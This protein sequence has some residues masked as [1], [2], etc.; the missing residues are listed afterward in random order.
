MCD[1][2]NIWYE[3]G[4]LFEG[5]ID[6]GSDIYLASGSDPTWTISCAGELPTPV[7]GCTFCLLQ[8]NCGCGVSS[9]HF[10]IPSKIS[11]CQSNLVLKRPT[12]LHLVNMHVMSTFFANLARNFTATT[13][14]ELHPQIEVPPLEALHAD[15]SQVAA[16]EKHFKFSFHKL[17]DN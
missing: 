2:C 5:A 16:K 7:Q 13:S 11:H 12:I 1:T 15:W 3:A 4:Q 9:L 14:F 17:A 8:I 10:K 6:L